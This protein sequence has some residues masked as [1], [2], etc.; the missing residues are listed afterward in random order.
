VLAALAAA[1]ATPPVPPPPEPEPQHWAYERVVKT[2]DG[3]V[4]LFDPRDLAHHAHEP[5]DWPRHGFAFANDLATGRFAA[6]LTG[7]DG[8]HRVRVTSAPLGARELAVAGPRATQR[9]RVVDRRLLLAGGGDVWPSL[10][11]PRPP[12]PADPRW[13]GIADGDYKVTITVLDTALAPALPD[14][15]F[16][17][18]EVESIDTVAYAP[19]MP[20]LVVGAGPAVAG[21]DTSMLRYVERCGAVRRT[22][23]WSP[24]IDASLPLPGRAVE[25]RVPE[26]LHERRFALQ[27]GAL[28]ADEPVIIARESSVGMLG[29]QFSPRRWREPRREQGLY[30][31]LFEAEGRIDCAVRITGIDGLG[32]ELKLI[33][34]PVPMP[35]DRL[36]PELVRALVDRFESFI[37]ISSDPAWRYKSGRVRHAPDDTS[38][39]LAV[40]DQLRLTPEESE[41]LLPMGNEE[42]VRWLLER[43][44]RPI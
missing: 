1:C 41:R 12:A 30:R 44:D 17:L 5:A 25:V 32:D 13:L 39:V 31:E 14:V 11:A 9:L 24:L 42:R 28:P 38:R 19:G 40:I 43:M 33:V 36:A 34:E 35:R 6:V 20:Q 3:I 16:R 2:S 18:E 27:A 37:A 15:V 8:Q 29:V 10:A 21:G 22:A 23:A 26:R 4:T 7:R